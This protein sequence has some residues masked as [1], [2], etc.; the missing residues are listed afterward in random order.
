MYYAR[1]TILK[2]ITFIQIFTSKNNSDFS[3]G[4]YL[5]SIGL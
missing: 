5:E 3:K 4:G 1:G 2:H